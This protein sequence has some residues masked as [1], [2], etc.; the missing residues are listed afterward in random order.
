MKY[1]VNF[2]NTGYIEDGI[3]TI[4]PS[5]GIDGTEIRI[6]KKDET[7]KVLASAVLDVEVMFKNGGKVSV[8]EKGGR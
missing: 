6:E 4:D 2:C 7:G 8:F 5:N 1:F 3:L